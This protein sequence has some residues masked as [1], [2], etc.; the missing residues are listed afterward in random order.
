MRSARVR[1]DPNETG[2]EC[3]LAFTAR[4]ACVEEG[5]QTLRQGTRVV[6]DATRFAQFGRWQGEI[7]YGGKT[8]LVDASRVY[9][10]KD[11]SW[12]IRPIGEPE[13]GGAPAMRLPQFFFLWAPI[14]WQD[15]CT[16]FGV[17]EDER[18]CA[19]Q[20]DGAIVPVY[21]SPEQ[22]PGVEDPGIER[23]ASVSH[24]IA[25]EKGTRRARSV[26]IALIEPTGVRHVIE[27]EPVL[28]FHMKGIG[29][30][31]PEWGHGRWK[32]ELAV[33]GES[34]KTDELNPLALENLHIQQVVRARMDGREGVGALE[35]ICIG[36]HATSG[37]KEF[38]DGAE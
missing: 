25:Y 36:P 5:R 20:Q 10:T 15:S 3:D 34:W 21:D 35:Q 1:L 11:R 12:G 31:H 26:E 4:T 37:F 16:H 14:H 17:F 7:R 38:L 18:G 33:G 8:L 32:G 27:L 9:G 13:T 6:Y 2:I 23:M 28:R 19:W 24:R 22:I 30:M 29:Y